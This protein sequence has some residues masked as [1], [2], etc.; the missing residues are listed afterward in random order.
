MNE[1]AIF[2]SCNQRLEVIKVSRRNF[3]MPYI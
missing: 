1:G 3:N 2:E